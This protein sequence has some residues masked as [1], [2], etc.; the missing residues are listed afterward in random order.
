MNVYRDTVFIRTKNSLHFVFTERI[1]EIGKAKGSILDA[2]HLNVIVSFSG[3][4][5]VRTILDEL[6]NSF[7]C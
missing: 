4:R 5:N 7:A 1:Q 2:W 3:N 6:S